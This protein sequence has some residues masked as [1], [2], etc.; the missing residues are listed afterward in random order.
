MHVKL[1]F[2]LRLVLVY[3]L[4]STA[5]SSGGGK[6]KSRF[7]SISQSSKIL[8]ICDFLTP[9]CFCF[10]NC[11][12]GFL[13]YFGYG[14]WHSVERQRLLQGGGSHGQNHSKSGQVAEVVKEQ[15]SFVCQEKY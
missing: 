15:E 10:L 2:L 8:C 5:H 11:F 9:S 12:K 3:T 13:I 7:H 14:L 1:R 6:K 4:R